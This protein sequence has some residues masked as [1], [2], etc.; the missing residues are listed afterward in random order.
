MDIGRVFSRSI[1][2]MWKHKFL[3]L[4]GFILSVSGGG[5]GN[6]GANFGNRF[7]AGGGTGPGNVQ[8]Q[9]VV[10][11][12]I[13]LVGLVVLLLLLVLVFYLR[14]V[15]RGAIVSAVRDIEGQGTTTLA[16]AW[17]NGR[18]FYVRLLSL[19]LVVNIPLVL[20]SILVIVV[21]ALPLIGLIASGR[22]N[23]ETPGAFF[24]TLG[25]TGALALCCAIVCIA[26][27]GLVIHPLY[28]FAARAIVIE[29]LKLGEGIRRGLAHAREHVGNVIVV[30]VLLIIA[31][32]GWTILMLIITLPIGAVAL[33]ALFSRQFDLNV[34]LIL[35]LVLGIPLLIVLAAIQAVFQTFEENVWTET[36][37][38][39]LNPPAPV[40]APTA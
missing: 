37:L 17:K 31:R 21:A 32:I 25:L 36:Y 39:L 4:F 15:A 8:I 5:G 18:T 24:A 20:F 3:W 30:Y 40:P 1:E 33:V 28:Q 38:A 10:L 12:L 23:G 16:Q 27:I 26:L 19:G 13:I 9:P 35:A 29:D 22:A 11:G 34:V 14:F 2:V 7:P 6:G